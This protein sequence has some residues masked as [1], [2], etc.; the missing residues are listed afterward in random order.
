M[1]YRG[2]EIIYTIRLKELLMAEAKGKERWQW[3]RAI[4]K[5]LRKRL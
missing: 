4:W 3:I 5:K 2:K 1:D